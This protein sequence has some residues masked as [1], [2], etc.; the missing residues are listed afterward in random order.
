MRIFMNGQDW[1][2]AGQFRI[3]PPEFSGHTR[4]REYFNE[5]WVTSQGSV[6]DECIATNGPGGLE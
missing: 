5:E 3:F 6:I 4:T 2:L 1:K